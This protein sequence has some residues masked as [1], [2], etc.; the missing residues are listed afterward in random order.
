MFKTNIGIVI[1]MSN[2]YERFFFINSAFAFPTTL[3]NSSSGASLMRF[4]LLKCL[5]NAL[6]VVSPIPFIESREIG[7]A[8][9]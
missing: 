5:S 7:R 8:H 9:V 4:T 2:D 1:V 6:F 3:A